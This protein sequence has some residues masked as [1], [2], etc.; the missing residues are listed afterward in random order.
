MSVAMKLPLSI[1]PWLSAH[2]QGH[3]EHSFFLILEF[4]ELVLIENGVP[5]PHTHFK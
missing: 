3:S 2:S 5:P 1:P 4:L